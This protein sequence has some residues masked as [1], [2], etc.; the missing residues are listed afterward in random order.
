MDDALTTNRTVV[1][2]VSTVLSCSCSATPSVQLLLVTICDRLVA[3]YRAMMRDDGAVPRSLNVQDDEHSERILPQPIT[4]GGFAV[5]P[6][7][8]RRMREQLVFGELERVRG[9]VRRFAQRV[10]ETK[11]YNPSGQGQKIFE[12]LNCLLR[13]Q[14][15][16]QASITHGQGG[17]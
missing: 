14:L 16:E 1:E 12:I 13:D 6:A 2:L 11:A 3:W 9:L 4:M 5:D 7:M 15:R 8:Q 17:W 10:Q